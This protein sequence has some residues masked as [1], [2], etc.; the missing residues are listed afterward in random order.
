MIGRSVWAVRVTSKKKKY[1]EKSQKGDKSPYRRDAMGG[2]ILTK[3]GMNADYD[4]LGT[5]AKFVL[6]RVRGLAFSGG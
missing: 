4:K 3:F 5:Y 1:E 2:A 6:N